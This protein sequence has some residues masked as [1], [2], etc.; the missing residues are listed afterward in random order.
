MADMHKTK[1]VPGFASVAMAFLLCAQASAQG[2][3]YK[4]TDG[5][6]QLPD[7]FEWGQVIAVDVDADGNLYAFHRCSSNTCV[8]RDEPPLLKFDSTGKHLMSWGSGM[9]VWPHGLDIDGEG[10]VWITDG[11]PEGGRGEQV[12][13]IGADGEVLMTIGT[14]GVAGDGPYTFDGVSDVEVAADGSIFIADGHNN[15]R[16]VKYSPEGEFIMEWGTAGPEPGEFNQPHALA[17]DSEGR[18]FVSDRENLRIQIFDQEGNFIDAWTQFGRVSGI[19]ISPDD[20]LYLAAQNDAYPDFETGIYVVSAR[21]GTVKTMI[22]DVYTESVVADS[23]GAVYT[24]I[25]GRTGEPQV[26]VDALQRFVVQ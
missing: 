21:D 12:L 23:N 15:N 24:G 14:A 2:T 20:T 10:N 16:I 4:Q 3:S 1:Y 25:R 9:L 8:D 22:S 17:M 7:G 19:A 18:L 5:W 6:A 26:S 11:R 13:K